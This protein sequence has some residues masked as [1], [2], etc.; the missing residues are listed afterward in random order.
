MRLK[1]VRIENF[2]IIDNC[3]IEFDEQFNLIIGNNGTGKTSILEAIT[4][5]LSGFIAGI[6]E[7]KPI[8]FNKEDIRMKTELTGEGSYHITYMTP[9]KVQCTVEVQGNEVI[10]WERSLTSYKSSRVTTPKNVTRYAQ[11]LIDDSHSVLPILSYQSA[12]RMW[13]QKREKWKDAFKENFSRSIG[14]M[15]CMATESNMKL[16]T[17][18]CKRM[19]YIEYKEEKKIL[20]YE[21]VRKTVGKFISI[22]EERDLESTITYDKRI[23]ELVYDTGEERIPVRLLSTGYR[24]IVGMVAD[25][26]YRMAVLNPNLGSEIVD[27]TDG[28]VIIDEI[29]L[30]IH[31]KWQW[32]IVNALIQTFPAVQFISTTHSPIVISSC[33]DK[34]IISLYDMDMTTINV[35][36]GVKNQ[37]SPYGW[38]V[39]DVLKKFMLTDDRDPELQEKLDIVKNL[40]MKK[41]R[42]KLDDSESEQLTKIKT[43]LY[44][45]L[46]ENDPA[47]DLMELQSIENILRMSGRS[48]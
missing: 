23:E 32:L 39:N 37:I 5:G 44:D 45:Y 12:G 3:E 35:E 4:V 41:F 46:P 47:V 6:H 27:K 9:T 11:S 30:H 15:D 33:K 43:E 18:W 2:R 22:L 42:Q 7:V 25:I 19:D 20:E 31:P 48:E 36:M 8:K 13:S 17:N 10:E 38:Q 16:L 29:D 24:S 26:A 21:V 1:K 28:I 14:Y 34:K 40:T